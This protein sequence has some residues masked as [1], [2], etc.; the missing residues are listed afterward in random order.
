M[1]KA[2]G[3]KITWVFD[4]DSA[5]NPFIG[6]A[7]DTL[8]EAG[9]ELFIIDGADE[10]TGA[11]DTKHPYS[12]AHWGR[13]FNAAK[14]F[15]NTNPLIR[16]FDRRDFVKAEQK[17]LRK[18]KAQQGGELQFGRDA[19]YLRARIITAQAMSAIHTLLWKGIRRLALIRR[20]TIDTW[21]P[22]LKGF[23]SIMRH[24]GDTIVVS[25]PTSLL[26]AFA[27]A[28][29]SGRRIVYYPFELYGEQAAEYSRIVRWWERAILCAGVEALITQNDCRAEVYRER[30]HK[31]A[32]YIAHNYK[33]FSEPS[34]KGGLRDKL[35]IPAHTK[36]VLYEGVLIPGRWL[37]KLAEASLLLPDDMVM[38][39]LGP[40]KRWWDD[41]HE[42][43][44]AEPVARGKLHIALP[45]PH[46]ELLDLIADADAGV[47]IYDDSILNN[48]FCEPGKLSDYAF[49]E[50]PIVAPDFPTIGPFVRSLGIGSCFSS[51]TPH[52]MA[53]SIIAVLSRPRDSWRPALKAAARQLTWATQA[54]SLLA[55]VS[56]TP[57]KD[58]ASL[59]QSAPS[60]PANAALAWKNSLDILILVE[61][62]DREL[63][64]ACLIRALIEQRATRL[65]VKVA[66]FYTEA[67]SLI[68][69]H[70]PRVVVTPFFYAIDDKIMRDYVAAWSHA[71]FFNLAWEQILYGSQQT[72]KRPRDAFTR[73]RVRHLA[74]SRWFAEYLQGHGVMAEKTHWLGHP[75]YDLY[76]PKFR[77][78]FP[79]RKEIARAEGLDPEKR[80]VFF[81]ENF[82]W[83]FLGDAKLKSLNEQGVDIA[84][85]EAQRAYCRE[86][87]GASAKWLASIARRRDIE[88]ILRPRPAVNSS[89]IRDF[90]AQ[91]AGETPQNFHI[92]KSLSVREWIFASDIVVSSISTSLIEAAIAGKPIL[93]MSPTAVPETLWY[94]WCEFVAVAESEAVLEKAVAGELDMVGSLAV[95]RWAADNFKLG[96]APTDAIAN[97]LIRL[98][99]QTPRNIGASTPPAGEKPPWLESALA[100]APLRMR[101]QLRAK[102]QPDYF[103]NF[104]THEKDLFGDSE[105]RL[106]TQ[107]WRA[108]LWKLRRA[109]AA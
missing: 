61:H 13:N 49:S 28:R 37:D 91:E 68:E 34:T 82:R 48:Y 105:V 21:S 43:F 99:N 6:I 55:A 32:V 7:V 79:D 70:S 45:V 76:D 29:L 63:D 20:D 88:V 41:N 58:A 108:I 9:Y 10:P 15:I 73:D 107:K 14:N 109:A 16:F 97:L 3:G 30:G 84:D 40:T 31:G 83:A 72:L 1:T 23:F 102:Y 96:E 69:N 77:R 90:V 42:K 103:F 89:Q 5:R 50:I 106:R 62:A 26:A 87:L 93:R 104:E 92:I 51:F 71:T 12:R 101:H 65:R 22:Y 4:R 35:G 86:A 53:E 17:R 80:W 54:P 47:I 57:V 25:R 44:T 38:V 64:V 24:A 46:D 85:L 94:D 74:W 81:P 67:Q 11:P 56:G 27:V 60:P 100:V 36:I 75:L 52:G 98:V 33:P 78:Y 8:K 59:H 39:F 19:N 2:T 18:L 95:R 66:N